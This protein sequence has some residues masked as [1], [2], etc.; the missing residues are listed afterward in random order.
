VSR[1]LAV[2]P[3]SEM[4][5]HTSGALRFAESLASEVIAVH[6][7]MAGSD[8]ER[9]WRSGEQDVPLLVIDASNGS[10]ANAL[11]QAL[12]VLQRAEQPGQIS[13]VIPWCRDQDANELGLDELDN[14]VVHHAPAAG[15]EK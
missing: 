5:V 4:D 11:R 9:R 13:L 1:H 15:F 3:I 8:V 6:V 12:T 7:R 2:V 10:R 14:L